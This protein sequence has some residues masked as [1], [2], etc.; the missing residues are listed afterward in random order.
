MSRTFSLER[1]SIE[2]TN[3]C[4]KACYFCYNH[5]SPGAGTTWTADALTD[6]V[7]DCA[8]HGIKA[9]SFGGGEP[10]QYEEI[11]E[12]LQRLRGML[13][14]SITTNGLLLETHFD[15]LV[16]VAPNKV[17]VSI[18][19]PD[20]SDEV[21]RVIEQV[22]RLAAA[23]IK[24]GINFLVTRSGIEAAIESALRVR[25]AGIDNER[26]V[27]L[28]M[29]VS[30]TPTPRQVATV[31]GDK[32]FQSMSCLSRCAASPRFCSIGW[33]QTVAWCSYTSSRAQ[34]KALSYEALCSAL[35]DLGLEFCGGTEEALLSGQ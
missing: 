21:E 25:T 11:F 8:K 30:D 22:K 26:I 27:Y 17:H 7:T 15:R 24:S 13:F 2:V 23:G 20:R 31:A 34:L 3:K 18:H 33:D 28:P 14:R 29:R 6:F 5:S 12:V 32:P 10:L 35:T 4:A 16:Q 9:V 1:I 19:F